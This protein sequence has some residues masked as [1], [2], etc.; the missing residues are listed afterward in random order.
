M[1]ESVVACVIG[2]HCHCQAM[3]GEVGMCAHMHIYAFKTYNTLHIKY[4]NTFKSYAFKACHTS[5]C[6]QC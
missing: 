3:V 5:C 1:R 2:G 6:T 4:K